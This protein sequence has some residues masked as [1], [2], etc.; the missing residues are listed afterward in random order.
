MKKIIPFKVEKIW[1]Y[2]LWLRSPLKGK[3][4]YYENGRKT[5]DGLLIK[6]IQADEP[7]S[8]QIHPSDGAAYDLDE[9]EK[10]KAESWFVLD[11]DWTSKIVHGMSFWYWDTFD[12]LNRE[13]EEMD[14]RIIKNMKKV[15]EYFNVRRVNKGEF[16][17]I[18]AG[19]IHG[20]GFKGAANI[21]VIEAQTPSD[22]T[23][24]IYDYDRV[25]SKTGKP[26]DLHFVDANFSYEYRKNLCLIDD[27]TRPLEHGKFDGFEND[28]SQ[29]FIISNHAPTDKAWRAGYVITQSDK[30][31]Y[32]YCLYEVKANEVFP[33]GSIYFIAPK[34]KKD[35]DVF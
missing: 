17:D 8:I 6:I 20:L 25:D 27:E 33:E 28:F 4:T 7:L 9:R 2:E 31:E 34:Y 22:L 5:K 15:K 3:E 10:G 14:F 1:G 13:E 29:Q 32:G 23:Y 18:P 35:F 21:R 26:R 11:A 30:D 19:R 16:I 24:R 12:E